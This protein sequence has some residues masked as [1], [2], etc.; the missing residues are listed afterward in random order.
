M[1][2]M[3]LQEKLNL[4]STLEEYGFHEQA[5]RDWIYDEEHPEEI[6]HYTGSSS[7][8]ILKKMW[9]DVDSSDEDDEEEYEC[10]SE[11]LP[12]IFTNRKKESY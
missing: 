3:P 7:E 8:E 10:D 5:I 2:E 11:G 6:V 1:K 9:E 4:I 12:L